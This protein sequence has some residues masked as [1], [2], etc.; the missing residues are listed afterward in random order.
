[1]KVRAW[2]VEHLSDDKQSAALAAA[3]ELGL[4]A[5]VLYETWLRPNRGPLQPRHALWHRLDLLNRD[6]HPHAPR[7]K[8]GISLLVKLASRATLFRHCPHSHWAIWLT[9]GSTL[10]GVYIPPSIS[11]AEYANI[12]DDLQLALA[13]AFMERPRSQVVVGDF[14][15]RLGDLVGDHLTNNRRAATRSFISRSHMELLNSRMQRSNRRFTWRSPGGQSVVDLAMTRGAPCSSFFVGAPPVA[16]PHQLL[17]VDVADTVEEVIADPSRWAWSRRAFSDLKRRDLCAAL[18]APTMD[19]ISRIWAFVAERLDADL[20][21][22]GHSDD[23][24]IQLAQELVDAAYSATCE[25]IRCSL[26]GLACWD[27]ARARRG[28]QAHRHVD[29]R[30]LAESS[31]GFF[32]SSVKGALQ[33]AQQAEAADGAAPETPSV[34]EFANCYRELFA[35]GPATPQDPLIRNRRSTTS[36]S[37]EE[38]MF[39]SLGNVTEL[40]H[41]ARW[42]KAIGPDNLPADVFKCCGERA[43]P[44]LSNM[45][46]V[47]WS[48]QILPSVWK[49]A[50][51]VPIEKKGADL[52]DP[53]Q[54]RGIALQSHL[55]KL[56]EV[57]VRWMCRD[58]GWT[59]VHILQTGFQPKT[60]AIEAVYSMD[61]LTRRYDAVGQ[62]LSLV[63]LDIRKAY[64]RTPR[65]FIFRKLRRRGMPEH[66]IGVIQ[67]LLDSCQVVL[68]VDGRCSDPVEVQ[69]GVPQGD[70]LSPDMFNV[71]VDDLAER[72]V[73]V[74]NGFGGCPKY[75][76]IDIPLVMY[77]DDQTLAHGRHDAMQAMLDEAQRY[78]DEHQIAYNVNKCVVTHAEKN[79][80]WP[81]LSLNGSVVPVSST[82]SLLGVKITDGMMDHAAQLDDR[83]KK[84][85]RAITGLE[86]L[87]AF[88]TPEL[89]I[90]RKRLLLTA[91]GR[92]RVEYGMAI[93][94]HT[95]ADLAKVDSWM[96][97]MTSKCLGGGS[98]QGTSL[99]MRFCGIIPAH[100]RMAQLRMRFLA[101]LRDPTR[102]EPS[103][104]A[105][106][107]K[108]AATAPDRRRSRGSLTPREPLS[109]LRRLVRYMPIIDASQAL[110]QKY[111]GEFKSLWDR[112]PAPEEQTALESRA[113]TVALSQLAWSDSARRLKLLPL[114]Q[115]DFRV[116]H[117]AAYLPGNGGLMH[118]RWLSNLAPG[119]P[120]V[121]KPCCNCDAQYRVSRYH[122]TRC[123]DAA[124]LL[125]SSYCAVAHATFFFQV[126]NPVDA[127]LMDLIPPNDRHA[128]ILKQL[129][130]CP[131]RP[132]QSAQDEDGAPTLPVVERVRPWRDER[133]QEQAH[134]ISSA[135]AEM[136]RLCCPRRQA[137]AVAPV[138]RSSTSTQAG[139]ERGDDRVPASQAF[140]PPF[141]RAVEVFTAGSGHESPPTLPP[142]R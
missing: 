76:D 27:P 129:D 26:I 111:A 105:A 2:N 74:A 89:S 15:A 70:V 55:K 65:A 9:A 118:G 67:S 56:F 51:V 88:R 69:V 98:G 17:M 120:A 12:L 90:A 42:K 57:Q 44:A 25:A 41:R 31:D 63:L 113:A 18:L 124:A 3:T 19:A 16:T 94:P 34:E 142:A 23:S 14:N 84:A 134:G 68:R 102:K 66:A 38:A 100:P 21:R 46:L 8:G 5:M 107:Y 112:D 130:K 7:G 108:K 103:L 131:I 86:I 40:L 85:Q 136:Q 30:A 29:W 45:F 119:H 101:G 139:R 79:K 36:L 33:T 11:A 28:H 1:M 93:A 96:R 73:T 125:G 75:G 60:G 140:P 91:Y 81:P 138:T 92:S 104:A 141:D 82:T 24:V 61:E 6:L 137:L 99:S 126:D 10:A 54:W 78:A 97:E 95:K 22:D 62:P 123:T 117:P 32:L 114:Q 116:P 83:L 52:S 72:L 47:L 58:R 39:F 64:D 71:F 43:A 53:A 37:D 122:L 121:G 80:D 50:F 127:M 35:A 106:V 49:R 135:I 13:D 87:G 133:W 110:T 128:A 4:D 59:K 77:A 109:V 115:Q 20:Q 132:R 48:H